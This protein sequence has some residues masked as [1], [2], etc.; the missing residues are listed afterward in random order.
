MLFTEILNYQKMYFKFIPA[1]NLLNSPEGGK[2][3]IEA[4][5]MISLRILLMLTRDGVNEPPWLVIESIVA[6]VLQKTHKKQKGD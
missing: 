6:I 1:I 4:H 2:V 5:H 3:S